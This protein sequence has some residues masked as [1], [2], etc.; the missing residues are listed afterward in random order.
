MNKLLILLSALFFTACGTPSKESRREDI[1]GIEKKFHTEKFSEKLAEEF[2]KATTDYI[3][4]F[5]QD[6]MTPVYLFKQAD[7]YL[8]LKKPTDAINALKRLEKDFPSHRLVAD[9]ILQQ[10]IIYD[11]VLLKKDQAKILYHTFLNRFPT[12]KNA[13]VANQALQIIDLDP[14]KVIRNFES[15]ADTLLKKNIPGL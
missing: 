10:A 3:V 12:H 11:N 14:E 7:M 1:S 4:S 2:L 6:T 8:S 5:P 9:A 13:L 15:A